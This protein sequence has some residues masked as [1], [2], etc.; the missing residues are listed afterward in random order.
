[1]YSL[2]VGLNLIQGCQQLLA[3]KCKNKLYTMYFTHLYIKRWE[4]VHRV[5]SNM[6]YKMVAML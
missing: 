5:F 1:M 6:V 2:C 3:I 4:F